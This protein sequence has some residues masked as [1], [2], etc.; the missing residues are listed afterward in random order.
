MQFNVELRQRLEIEDMNTVLQCNT[1]RWY[2][3]VLRVDEN[4]WVEIC[5]EILDCDMED[6]K[7]EGDTR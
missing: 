7:L 1:L 5:M 2:G 6:G 4:D 3:R